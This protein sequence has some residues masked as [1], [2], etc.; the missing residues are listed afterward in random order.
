MRSRR[1]RS[2]VHAWTVSSPARQRRKGVAEDVLREGYASGTSMGSFIDAADIADMAVF[3][4][5]ERARFVSGQIIAVD[6]N[7]VNPD[8]A[9]LNG[10][11]RFDP[12]RPSLVVTFG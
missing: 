4:A 6:G 7:T 11:P 9:A 12:D 10:L 8:P 1:A 5:S 3:L 2:T